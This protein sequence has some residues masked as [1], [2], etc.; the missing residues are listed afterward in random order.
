[1]RLTTQ[2]VD[3]IKTGLAR[4]GRPEPESRRKSAHAKGYNISNGIDAGMKI[5]CEYTETQIAEHHRLKL[6]EPV[7]GQIGVINRGRI[8][9]LTYLESQEHL[10]NVLETFKLQV[11]LYR[12]WYGIFVAI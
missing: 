1:M 8:I 10:D 9:V 3:V 6:T 5:L 12:D 7:G 11:M 4:M 2:Q